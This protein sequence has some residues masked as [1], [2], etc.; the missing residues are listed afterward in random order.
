M[1]NEAVYI[2][3]TEKIGRSN[4][5]LGSRRE[6]SVERVGAHAV[7]KGLGSLP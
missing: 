1:N 4:K 2:G 7:A 6:G 5:G 3:N